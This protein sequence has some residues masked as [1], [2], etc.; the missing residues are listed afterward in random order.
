MFHG[1]SAFPLTPVK[2]EEIDE[3]SFERL[4]LRLT[5]A[6]VDSLGVL[7]S[8]G[9]YMYLSQA[10]RVRVVELAVAM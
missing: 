5:E 2:N 7:G 8:T 6:G 1:L 3:Q 4:I 10:E 9:N